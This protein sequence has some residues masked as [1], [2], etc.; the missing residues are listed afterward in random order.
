[1]CFM[2]SGDCIVVIGILLSILF[3]CGVISGVEGLG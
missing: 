3:M 1:M 2:C